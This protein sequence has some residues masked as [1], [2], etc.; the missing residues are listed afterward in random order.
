[1]FSNVFKKTKN[2]RLIVFINL[3]FIKKKCVL[4]ILDYHGPDDLGK[5]TIVSHRTSFC[6]DYETV[7]DLGEG[8]R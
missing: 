2:F 7:Q 5:T 4:A 6:S 1:M 8:E 3:V